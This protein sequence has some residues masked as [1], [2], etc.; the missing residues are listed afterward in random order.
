VSVT[1]TAVAVRILPRAWAGLVWYPQ[2]SVWPCRVTQIATHVMLYVSCGLP[3]AVAQ[4]ACIVPG[5]R[6]QNVPWSN[7]V[8]AVYLR[9]KHVHR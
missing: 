7:A 3:G 9:R 6:A 2:L 5:C 8:S 4:N 1:A